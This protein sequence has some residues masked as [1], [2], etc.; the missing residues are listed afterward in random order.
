MRRLALV[1]SLIFGTVSVILLFF[2]GLQF[3]RLEYFSTTVVQS[4][5][6]STG[7]LVTPEPISTVTA[8]ATEQA[9][10]LPSPTPTTANPNTPPPFGKDQVTTLA[11][12]ISVGTLILTIVFGWFS[13]YLRKRT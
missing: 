12:Q 10:P 8:S 1:L 4:T 11:L 6:N 3:L 13:I 9:E 5:P 2:V 7:Q